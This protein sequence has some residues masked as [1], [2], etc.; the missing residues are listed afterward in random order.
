M[1]R[2]PFVMLVVGPTYQFIFKHR[3]PADAPRSWKREWASVHRTNFGLLAVLTVMWLTVGIDRFLL[4]QLPITLIAGSLGVFLFYVQHQYED[5]YWRYSERWDYYAAGL[6]GSSHYVLPKVFQWLTGNIGLHHI[7]HLNS[8][9][10]NYNLQRCFDE[11]SKLHNVTQLKF[12][13]SVKTLWMTLW[14]EDEQRLVGFRDLKTIRAKLD[15]AAD[16]GEG[17]GEGEGEGI[18]GT[19]PEVVPRSWR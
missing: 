8:R 12:W 2:H 10:P 7:H 18:H 13:D 4:V 14:D 1:Y 5:T 6:E 9:I 15:A 16:P 19:K 11:N 3:Y 17:E